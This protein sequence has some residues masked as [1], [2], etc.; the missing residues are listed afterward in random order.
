VLQNV[1]HRGEKLVHHSRKRLIQLARVLV[2]AA[3][4]AGV[5][6]AVAVILLLT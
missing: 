5:R 2:V 1:T 6:A 4:P 3:A